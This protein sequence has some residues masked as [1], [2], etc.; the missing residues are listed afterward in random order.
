MSSMKRFSED[1]KVEIDCL[2]NIS[3]QL[4]SQKQQLAEIDTKVDAILRHVEGRPPVE[5]KDVLLKIAQEDANSFRETV[6]V[7]EMGVHPVEGQQQA[8][9][10][11]F[12]VE[13]EVHEFIQN[14]KLKVLLVQGGGGSGKSLFCHIFS[15]KLLEEKI[16]WIPVFINLPILK[17]PV[18]QVIDEHLR[19]NRFTEEEIVKMQ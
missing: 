9:Q 11:A 15:M 3:T 18:T 13:Q 8:D 1:F 7:P 4:D 14:E 2:Q 5:L 10:Q 19:N 12:E 16:E 6:F 17:E